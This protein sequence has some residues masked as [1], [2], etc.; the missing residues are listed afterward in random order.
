MGKEKPWIAVVSA[1][2]AA[3]SAVAT[4]VAA[5]IALNANAKSD[6]A[7]QRAAEAN[8]IAADANDIARR[9]QSRQAASEKRAEARLVEL[10]E[11]GGELV[12][13]FAL[14]TGTKIQQW[15]VVRNRSS[16]QTGGVWVEVT[17]N[18]VTRIDGVQSCSLYMLDAEFRPVA[19][20]FT[21]G[22]GTWRREMVKDPVEDLAPMPTKGT[23]SAKG[24][25]RIC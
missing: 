10:A 22:H 18:T 12:A 16:T 7:N 8:Q 24:P 17:D 6:E 3:V 11:E 15:Y 1:V 14:P 23:H 13:K 9:A 19:V 4:G 20:H 21:N 5:A 2:A 25:V